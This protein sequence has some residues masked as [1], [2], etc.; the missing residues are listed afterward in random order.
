[1]EALGL[2]AGEKAAAGQDRAIC[3]GKGKLEINPQS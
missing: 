3:L 1:M 2:G